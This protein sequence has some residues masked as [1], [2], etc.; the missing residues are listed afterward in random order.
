MPPACFLN[1]PTPLPLNGT[2][3]DIVRLSCGGV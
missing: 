3:K 2:E 1:A